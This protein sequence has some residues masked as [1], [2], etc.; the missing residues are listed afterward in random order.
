[1]VANLSAVLSID[2]GGSKVLVGIVDS[3]GTIHNKSREA[4]NDIAQPDDLLETIYRLCVEAVRNYP[5]GDIICAGANIPGLADS[6][7]GLWVYSPFSGIRDFPLAQELSQ[8]LKLPV[9]I[10]NDVNACA[11]AEIRFGACADVRDFIWVTISNGIG[12]SIVTDGKVYTGGH[13]N[14]GEIGHVCVD[15]HGY[16]CQCGNRGC[17]E[18]SAAGPAILRRYIEYSGITGDSAY[19][20]AEMIANKARSG[21]ETAIKVFEDTGYFLGKAVAA[22]V[23][24]LNPQ[25]VILGGGVS[26]GMDLFYPKMKMTLD[27]MVF[28]AANSDLSIERTALGYDAALF[29]AA[30]T[31][32]EGYTGL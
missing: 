3:K 25:K 28:R 32:F 11:M 2:I 10:E 22:A 17:A 21:D 9:F 8:R 15:E 16:M 26:A 12:G 1:M 14:A 7:R 31:G 30:T 6:S 24:L 19:L 18:A 29:G 27:S 4:I 13:G 5:G 23:N 20:S